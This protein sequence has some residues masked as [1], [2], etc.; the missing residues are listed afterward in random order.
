MSKEITKAGDLPKIKDPNHPVFWSE[1]VWIE[2][3]INEN[4]DILLKLELFK[5]LKIKKYEESLNGGWHEVN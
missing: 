3:W 5:D 2:S 4:P 1:E